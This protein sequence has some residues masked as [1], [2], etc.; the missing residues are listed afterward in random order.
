MKGIVF[1]NYLNNE[2]MELDKKNFKIEDDFETLLIDYINNNEL[3]RK[4][5]SK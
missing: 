1:E 3:I 2:I 4:I 5:N